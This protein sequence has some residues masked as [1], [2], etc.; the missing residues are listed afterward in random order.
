M[1]TARK[2][3][4]GIIGAA[5]IFGF[6]VGLINVVAPDVSSVNMNG[7]EIEGWNSIPVSMGIW[8]VMGLIFGLIASGIT[9]LFTRKKKA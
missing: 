1:T 8:G 3:F 9:A 7:E 4:F 5:L 2:V 6:L